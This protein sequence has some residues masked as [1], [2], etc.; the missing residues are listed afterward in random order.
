MVALIVLLQ[1]TLARDYLLAAEN[2][3]AAVK[4]SKNNWSL[5]NSPLLQTRVAKLASYHRLVPLSLLFN[6]ATANS[7]GRSQVGIFVFICATWRYE[8]C[9]LGLKVPL[10]DEINFLQKHSQHNDI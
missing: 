8:K 1:M 7:A 3:K 5:G 6:L 9:V 2:L 10:A 4:T